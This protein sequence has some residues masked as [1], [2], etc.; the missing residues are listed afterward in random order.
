MLIAG[1]LQPDI[2][3]IYL[4]SRDITRKPPEAR[5]FGMVFQGY[6]LFPHLSAAENISFPL[7]VRRMGRAEIRSRVESAIDLVRLQGL[8]DRM[9]HQLSGGQQQRVALARA[10]IFNPD[11][12]LLDEPLSALDK[13]LRTGLQAELRSLQ[14]RIGKSFLCVT[15]DQEEAISM[16]DEIAVLRDGRLV[17]QGTPR[18]LFDRPTSHFVA[19]FLGESNFIEGRTIGFDE[20]GL[21]YEAGGIVFSQTG[22]SSREGDSLLLSL[23]P[24]KIRLSDA[25]PRDVN[26]VRGVVSSCSYRG[27]EI[28]CVV[29]TPA[30]RLTVAHPIWQAS[31]LPESGRPVWLSW[32]ADAAIIV[33]DDRHA[34]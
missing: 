30:G 7:K 34:P 32:P 2:G 1:S 25:F 29:E 3:S 20:Q 24:S 15:H 13:K 33:T 28:L 8:E 5:N 10:L 4:G 27:T 9:P 22:G 26:Q 17:Q 21:K 16:S 19:E 14:R 12:L 6:A 23:R 31:F 11:I 18:D